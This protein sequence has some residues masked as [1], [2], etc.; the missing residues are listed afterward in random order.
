MVQ[1]FDKDK[2]GYL[3]L[4]WI[5]LGPNILYLN[6]HSSTR[7]HVIQIFYVW[8]SVDFLCSKKRGFDIL[9]LGFKRI[10]CVAKI[11]YLDVRWI[12]YGPDMLYLD[13]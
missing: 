11:L 8:T 7:L 12:I 4:Q 10:L 1:I 5:I 9:Y 13:F 3:D 2:P 6:F